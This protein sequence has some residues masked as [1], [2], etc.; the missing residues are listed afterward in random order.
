VLG[1]LVALYL[2]I[3]VYAMQQSVPELRAG[4]EPA[5]EF[6]GALTTLS[7]MLLVFGGLAGAAYGGTVAG[8]EWGWGTFRVALTRG[9]SR[10][11][12][13]VGL[14]LAIALLFLTAW[15]LLYVVGIGLL[16]AAASVSGFDTGGLLDPANL[17]HH[18]AILVVGWWAGL[19]EV[20]LAFAISFVARS[21]VAGVA[22]V[23]GV[24]F[25]ELL[26]GSLV[27]ADA[28]RLA[29][30]TAATELVTAAAQTGMDAELAGPLV[31]TTGYLL[32]AIA[33][34]GLVAHRSEVR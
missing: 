29:P 6:P 19:M 16:L 33:V 9:E 17:G 20:A 23:M 21:T 8:S 28:L 2:V 12:Y 31:V 1:L 14:L 13:V 5:L 25:I 18:V 27:P 30:I 24:T 15:A 32:L 3:G 34:A 22:A 26:V 4:I 11:R 10:V 7:Q